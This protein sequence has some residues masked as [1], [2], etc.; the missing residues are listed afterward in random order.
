MTLHPQAAAHLLAAADTPGV[1]ELTVPQARLVAL[2]YVALQ[3]EPIDLPTEHRFIRGPTADLPIRILRPDAR[4]GPRPTIIVL[5]GSGWAIGT[6]DLV[7]EPARR[8][9]ADTGFTVITI[10][11]QKAPEHRFPIPLQD[12]VAGIEWVREH[13]VE[14]GVDPARVGV[15]G[16]SA[17]GTLAA[18]ATAALNERWTTE[19][20]ADVG[21]AGTT[22]T[23]R[24]VAA[25]GLLYPAL[26]AVADSDSYREF[27][28]GHGLDAADMAWFWSHYLG[29]AVADDTRRDPRVS[30]LRAP[31]VAALPPTY[32]A[33]AGH[34]VLRDEGEAYADRLRAADVPVVSHRFPGMIHGF[35]WMDAVLDD[36]RTLQT[37]LADFLRAHLGAP[38]GTGAATAI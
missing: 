23:G 29:D 12:C 13:A 36:A 27:A 28:G 4:P 26:D 21:T 6:L 37:A 14:L 7:D 19:R 11:Y 33:T 1:A 24:P 3:R 2:G 5:H 35:W 38:P 16:D 31:S 25:L 17:G 9:A 10:N 22:D 8:L 32:L 18:A 20:T 30:P 15:V 34:D